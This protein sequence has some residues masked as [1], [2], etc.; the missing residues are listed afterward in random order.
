VCIIWGIA[1]ILLAL[2]IP[3]EAFFMSSLS[4]H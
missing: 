1:I 3:M 4:Q 2:A